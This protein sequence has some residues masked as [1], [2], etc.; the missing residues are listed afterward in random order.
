MIYVL[1]EAAWTEKVPVTVHGPFDTPELAHLYAEENNVSGVVDL[2][3][4]PYPH[5]QQTPICHDTVFSQQFPSCRGVCYD[6]Y[7]SRA[8]SLRS[9]L[10]A[11]PKE[12]SMVTIGD[13]ELPE[14][15]SY[16]SLTTW[17]SCGWSYYLNRVKKIQELPAWWFYGGS[18]VH[19][20]T[21]EWDR[22]HL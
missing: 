1:I 10:L 15:I 12:R 11:Q 21:E 18:A 7:A 2:L 22:K 9:C 4:K 20:A 6:C 3:I 16:S 13:H 5:P 19:R 8:G 14:H 17:L